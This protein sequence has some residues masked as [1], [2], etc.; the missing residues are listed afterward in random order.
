M[1]GRLREFRSAEVPIEVDHM[2]EGPLVFGGPVNA[3]AAV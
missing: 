2:S 1:A 3:A